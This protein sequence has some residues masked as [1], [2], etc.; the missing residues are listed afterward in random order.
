MD[1]FAGADGGG[2]NPGFL[3]SRWLQHRCDEHS[4][5]CK[6]MLFFVDW[7]YSICKSRLMI[8]PGVKYVKVVY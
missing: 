8:I 4:G 6:A 2:Y 3:H 1:T 5:T 7:L